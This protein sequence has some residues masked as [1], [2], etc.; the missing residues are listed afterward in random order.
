[1]SESGAR[2]RSYRGCMP[3]IHASAWVAPG[4]VVVGDVE[5]GA[6]ASI[7][8][9]VVIRGDVH[10]VRIG[11]RTNVQ[12]Q[13][14]L[15][16]TAGRFATEVGDEVTV[17]HKAVVHGCRV[18]DAALIGVGAIVLDGARVGEGALVGAGAVVT[19]GAVIPARTL[20]LGTPAKAVRDLT[21][22][23]RAMQRERTLAYV[24]TARH[25]RAAGR[26]GRDS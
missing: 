10:H 15:H 24:E 11:D 6:D 20:A 7:W 13:S 5:I 3:R 2:I 17:G 18:E 25:H 9:G 14:V 23:E 12:D 16:V 8:Y 22:E 26:P 4:A 19:P 21:D 1:M